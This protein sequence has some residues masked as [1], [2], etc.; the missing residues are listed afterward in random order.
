MDIAAVRAGLAAAAATITGLTTYAYV[1]DSVTEPC[2]YP[3]G[4]E[5]DFDRAFVR[6]LDEVNFTCYILVSRADDATG[7]ARLDAFLKGSGATSLKAAL[8]AARGAPG[9]LALSGAADDL[10]VTRVEGYGQYTIGDTVY[11]GAKLLVTVI[12]SG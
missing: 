1:P 12:G 10:H 2:F 6:G 8:E 11:Y 7:Q 4:Y 9:Q 5:V 3:G